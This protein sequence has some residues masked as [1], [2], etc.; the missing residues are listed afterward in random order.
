MPKLSRGEF[1]KLRQDWYKILEDTGFKDIEK[2]R[3][4]Q[5]VLRQN[6]AHC[7]RYDDEFSKHIKEEY[8]RRMGQTVQDEATVFRNETDKHILMMHAEGAEI[9]AIVEELIRLGMDRN[10]SSVRFI[11]RKYESDWKFKYYAPKQLNIKKIK[12]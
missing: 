9:K 5:L 11:I 4:D 1:M 6:A 3:G 2:I 7:Y 10:R 12:T 8:F